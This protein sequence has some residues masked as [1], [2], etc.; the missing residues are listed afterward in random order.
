MKLVRSL[1]LV[2]VGFSAG[3]AADHLARGHRAV[4]RGPAN[5]PAAAAVTPPGERD[6]AEDLKGQMMWDPN[7]RCF[8]GG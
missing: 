5:P 7:S 4:A 2:V 1:L 3:A 6:P 8:L